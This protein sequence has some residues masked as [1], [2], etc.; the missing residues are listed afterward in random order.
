MQK[1]IDIILSIISQINSFNNKDFLGIE[2]PPQRIPS[3][4]KYE[5]YYLLCSN[6]II[7]NIG[8]FSDEFKIYYNKYN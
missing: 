1:I 2:Y 7:P 6:K 3:I 5:N 8:I 4:K